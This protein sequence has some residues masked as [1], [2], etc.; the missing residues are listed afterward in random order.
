M[1]VSHYGRLEISYV[2]IE[3]VRGMN[4][5]GRNYNISRAVLTQTCASHVVGNFPAFFSFTK[6]KEEKTMHTGNEEFTS[7]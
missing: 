3:F 4:N 2:L 7:E 1:C 5:A 6:K